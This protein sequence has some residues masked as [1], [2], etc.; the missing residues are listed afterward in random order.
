MQRGL[1]GSEMCIRDRYQR[2]VHGQKER[3]ALLFCCQLKITVNFGKLPKGFQ[4]HVD[5]TIYTFLS[6]CNADLRMHKRGRSPLEPLYIEDEREQCAFCLR[7]MSQPKNFLNNA[8]I[9][10]MYKTYMDCYSADSSRGSPRNPLSSRRSQIPPVISRL[11]PTMTQVEFIAHQNDPGWLSRKVPACPTCFKILSS[12][13][14]EKYLKKRQYWNSVLIYALR[15]HNHSAN[16]SY[17]I[18]KV[19]N[20]SCQYSALLTRNKRP[21]LLSTQRGISKNQTQLYTSE[22]HP[23]PEPYR[24]NNSINSLSQKKVALKRFIRLATPF[25]SPNPAP[26]TFRHRKLH[27]TSIN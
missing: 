1:V 13:N 11:Y 6:R 23:A 16:K 9:M 19:R 24:T 3:I 8:K 12:F 17:I 18:S 2:R 25:K 7:K 14:L 15:L 4:R 5:S 10:E 20:A 26:R 27:L 22:F 21:S